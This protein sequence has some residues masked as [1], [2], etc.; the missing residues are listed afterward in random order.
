ML[1]SITTGLA[2][3]RGVVKVVRPLIIIVIHSLLVT[4]IYQVLSRLRGRSGSFHVG[5]SGRGPAK[6]KPKMRVNTEKGREGRM[7]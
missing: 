5:M 1:G 7:W 6:S 3:L 2:S 4:M